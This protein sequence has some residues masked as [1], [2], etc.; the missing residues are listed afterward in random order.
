MTLWEVVGGS[1]TGG[2]LIREGQSFGS[3]AFAERLAYGSTIEELANVDGRLHYKL[4]SGDGPKEGWA[5][6]TITARHARKSEVLQTESFNSACHVEYRKDIIVPKRHPEESARRVEVEE[7]A[8]SSNGPVEIDEMLQANVIA[9]AQ[10]KCAEFRKYVPKYHVF[11]FPLAQPQYRIFCFPPAGGAESVYTAKKTPFMN[12]VLETNSVEVVALQYPGRENML[13]D[14]LHT[15]LATLSSLILAVIYDKIADG[16]PYFVWG[17]SVGTWLCFEVLMLAR[18]VGLPMPKAA[19]LNAFP[20]PHIP[21]EKR[22]WQKSENLEDEEFKE[23]LRLWDDAHFNGPS[24]VTLFRADN[25]PIY[26]PIMRADFHLFD[27]YEFTH[28]G[29]PKFDF[30][31]HCWHMDDEHFNSADMIK[32]WRHWTSNKF[33]FCKLPMGHL[34]CLYKEEFKNEYLAKVT[35]VFK[36]YCNLKETSVNQNTPAATLSETMEKRRRARRYRY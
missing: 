29:A 28:Y 24:G 16:V 35:E 18:K 32:S 3:P 6:L 30:P 19:V 26:G 13:K 36:D 27:E 15:S 5:S 31:L 9:D 23:E 22:P 20:A 25:W 7:A 34:S 12:W 14:G 8:V 33:E 1:D 11:K 17:H 2:V 4:V 21:E 10:E